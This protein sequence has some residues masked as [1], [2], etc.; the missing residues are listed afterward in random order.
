ME[1]F[2]QMLNECIRIG[3]SENKTSFMALRYACYPELKKYEINSAYKN[4]SISRANG[5]LSNYRKLLK[6]GRKVRTPYCWKPMLT[7]CKGFVL[8][9]EGNTIVLPSK[10]RIPLN[11]YIVKKIRGLEIRSITVRKRLSR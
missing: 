10:V 4:N 1:T 9:V 8:R 5:I 11:G 7:T 3:L 2:R 6:K